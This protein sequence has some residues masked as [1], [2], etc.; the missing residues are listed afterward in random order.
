MPARA[1]IA[2][3]LNR[4]AARAITLESTVPKLINPT[5]QAKRQSVVDFLENAVPS[6][7]EEA[8]DALNDL[9][10]A[11]TETGKAGELVIKIKMRPI[12]GKAGQME[13]EADVK[14]KLPQPARGKTILFATPDNNLQ[15]TDPRQQTLEGVRDVNQESVAQQKGEVRTVAP[16]AKQA[17][18]AVTH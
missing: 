10:H 2:P 8:T 3:S 15:R 4:P 14:V 5:L 16:E 11:T 13:L 17:L 9:V 18:R 12:G 7:A 1:L 6:V